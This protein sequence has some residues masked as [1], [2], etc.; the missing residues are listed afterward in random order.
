MRE[1]MCGTPEIMNGDQVKSAA[2][3]RQIEDQLYDICRMINHARHLK[4]C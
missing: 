2:D 1:I 3:T 4:S